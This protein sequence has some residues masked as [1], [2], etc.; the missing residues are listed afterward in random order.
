M[1]YWLLKS[2]PEEFSWDHLVAAGVSMWD[3][4]RNF[5]AARNLRAMQLGDQAFFY[6]SGVARS[7]AGIVEI[8]KTHY[9]D[10]TDPTGKF[11]AVDVK[12]VRPVKRPVTLAEIK[13]DPRFAQMKLVRQARLSVSPIGPENWKRLCAMAE[14]TP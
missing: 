9:R 11:V 5:T 8:V 1:D 12:P 7:I 10:P 14:T 3:G 2:E 13:A 4:V 6:H